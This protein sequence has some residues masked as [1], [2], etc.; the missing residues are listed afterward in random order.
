MIDSR[1]LFLFFAIQQVSD[2]TQLFCRML[3]S[4]NLFTKL[5]LLG[6]FFAEN[7]VDI[8]HEFPP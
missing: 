3:Q 7:F 5:R 2:V 1:I 4:L 8:F 6:L